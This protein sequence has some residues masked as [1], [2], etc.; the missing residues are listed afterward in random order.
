[1]FR[2]G[3]EVMV[4]DSFIR[5]FFR[6]IKYI[7]GNK[8]ASGRLKLER[9]QPQGG[10]EMIKGLSKRVI[11]VKSP[12]PALFE[13]AIFIIREDVFRRRN[14]PDVI[15]EAQRAANI[16][17]RKTQQSPLGLAARL[18]PPAYLAAGAAAAGIAWL[19]VYLVGI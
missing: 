4:R 8:G 18:S 14:A 16:Y 15:K 3:R 9:D 13:E 6:Q 17:L 11:V 2:N 12:D 1:M 7:L 10:R 19:A 5:A